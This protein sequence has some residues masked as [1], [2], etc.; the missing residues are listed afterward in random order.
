MRLLSQMWS[1][2]QGSLFPFLEEVL[3]P[4]SENQKQLV[5]I[6]EVVRIEEFVRDSQKIRGRPPE[7]R[8]ALAR[9]FVAKA[10]YNCSS[11]RDLITYLHDSPNLRRICGYET[12]SAIPHESTF[13][14]AF[15]EFAESE[16]PQ[17][18]QAALIEKHRK[19]QLVG[20]ISRDSTAIEGNEKPTPKVKK[21]EEG[22]RKPA[23]KRG[24]SRKGERLP[25]KEA[26]RLER[27]QTMTLD[28]MLD[29]LP[30]ACDRGTKRN[31]KGY[32][33]SWVGYKLHMDCAD[34]GIPI[35]VVLTSASLHD[36]QAAIPL[37]EMTERRVTYLYELM[38]S[39][40]DAER[41]REHSDSR[42]HVPIIDHNPRGGQKKELD[43][44]TKAR[45]KER[46]TVERAFGRLKEEFGATHVQVRGPTKVMA[47]L[48]FGILALTA[49]Q[50][51]RLVM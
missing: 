21:E 16:L 35:S 39:A 10:I 13:S 48:M 19:E 33:E 2:I 37:A 15:D 22:E 5:A 4:L 42:N 46:T 17:R 29:D 45:Y 3:E 47:H 38:D 8:K 24:R 36:S 1:M 11:T 40:Y 27:Q 14:R 34:G 26:T 43:P 6:L 51:L 49:D 41:I 20:H 12:N 32:K 30:K 28:E 25:A 31:S 18:V 9:A 50:L 7:N 44:A 23:R